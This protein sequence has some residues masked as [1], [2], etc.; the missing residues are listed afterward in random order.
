MRSRL[1]AAALLL[2][3]V[4]LASAQNR[5]DKSV[6]ATQ[7]TAP[8]YAREIAPIIFNNC[9]VCHHEGGAG[10]FPLMNYEQVKSHARQIAS[11]TRSR[12]MPP[13][14]AEAQPLKFVDERRLTP[15]QIATIQKWYEQG[16]P[17]GKTS[18][19]PRAP[20]FEEGWLLGRPDLVVKA[21]KPYTLPAS[22]SDQYW[23]FVLPVPIA[24]TRW[25]RAVDIH[26]GEKRLVHHA[27]MLVDRTGSARLMEKDPG[28][29][30]GGMEI[31]LE[32]E[33]FDPDSHFLFW[34]PGSVPYNEP[35]GMAMRLDPGNNLLLNLH[36]QP[37]GKEEQVQSSVGL[38][39]TDKPATLH[40]M[41]LQLQND[42]ALD[43]PAGEANFVVTTDLTLPIDVDV[44][45]IYP[46]AHY[47]GRDLLATAILPDGVKKTLIHIPHW[48]LKWQGVFR[49]E[50]PVRL[51][52]G[53][54]IE[55]RYVYDNSIDNVNNPSQ[56]PVRVK[57]GNRAS[58]EMA[59]LWL[60]VLPV[61][62]ETNGVDSR[63]VLMEALARRT[64]ENDPADF[65]AHY[66][67]AAM[68]MSEGRTREAIRH[69]EEAVKI[70]PEHAV[71]NNSLGAA[72]MA[73]GDTQ[74]AVPYFEQA[75]Q[76]RPD[77]FDAHYNLGLAEIGSGRLSAALE[78]F[79]A[80]EKLSP[81]D[82]NVQANYGAALAQAGKLKEATEHL[83]K[84]LALNPENRD[85][86]ENLEEVKR[87]LAGSQSVK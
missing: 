16:A 25:L 1:I 28:A 82:A 71:A 35:D 42:K 60:Q 3:A 7:P 43:I 17:E 50:K 65:E 37:S 23:N 22:G 36:L 51:P 12:F 26:P 44:L 9:A 70:R 68:M 78:Q 10:P 14:L 63:A 86:R 69:Y 32:S 11:V 84:A 49:Y 46:H 66:N 41:L 56:P 27:N 34:K 53:T 33:A 74:A 73:K 13:W 21:E 62:A 39:F 40:P 87:M 83:E 55:M 57:S 2:A 47:L 72:L 52:K 59:H 15:E 61:Q 18:D 24:E 58:D 5:A 64:L 67:L 45:A 4:G 8:T 29:G 20:K 85:A 81:Q 48:D 19:L 31:S 30:F 6:R 79:S 76:V 54:R 38:Y 77:Y 75:L 80:A